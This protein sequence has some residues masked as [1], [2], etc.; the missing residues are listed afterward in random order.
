MIKIFERFNELD[1]YGEENWEDDESMTVGNLM[2]SKNL[3][4]CK[5]YEAIELC[6]DIKENGHDDWRL[7]TKEELNELYKY[8]KKFGGFGNYIYWS[9]SDYLF[10]THAWCQSFDNG[11][12]GA[13]YKKYLGIY[14]RAVRNL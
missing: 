8:H 4:M 12:Q 11:D 5:W 6:K 3:G 1:P 7:P 14:V 10:D 9:S 13:N 2:V